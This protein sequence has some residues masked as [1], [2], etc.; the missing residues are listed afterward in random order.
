DD[1]VV[2]PA[3][4]AD[5]GDTIT[6]S[7]SVENTGNA[8][9]TNIVVT[10]PLLPSLNCTIANLAI[11]A[12]ASC[13]ATG[14]V[15]T[16]LASDISARHRDNTAAATSNEGAVDTDTEDI[17]LPILFDP[18]FG[19]KE[20]DDAG[21]PLLRWT[22]VW[23]NDSN[24]DPLDAEI[25][26]PIPVGTTYFGGSLGCTAQGTSA[27]ITCTYDSINNRIVWTGTIGD[28]LGATDAATADNEIIITYQVTIPSTLNSAFNQATL[29]ADLN[30]DGVI[31]PNDGEVV[32]AQASSNW[33][34]R[35][36][37]ETGF[38]PGVQTELPPRSSRNAYSNLGTIWLEIPKLGVRTTIVGVP[39]VADRW[40]VSWLSNQAGWLAGTAF[41]SYN[42][43][44]VLTAHVYLPSGLPGPFMNLS[45]LTWE[46][47]IIV[48]AYGQQYIFQVRSNDLILPN[49]PGA[50]QHEEYP[51]LTLL[52]CK[53]YND[54]KGV[55]DYRVRVMAVLMNVVPDIYH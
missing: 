26:D 33:T 34:R 50:I 3:G 48:H 44:S 11:G 46:D 6:Y 22:M 36:L 38:A 24:T 43:N 14:N 29:D 20:F 42:G 21:L 35:T 31:D 9:L 8:A 15:Y 27:T 53:G 19:I 5:A 4:S 30:G 55:Y 41:P 40:D 13:T 10:D 7:F 54:D 23:I 49:D 16:L 52:T 47:R 28:D 37:P 25:Y 18:P 1:T 32:V 39:L 2:S 45:E 17:T 51:W 12:T